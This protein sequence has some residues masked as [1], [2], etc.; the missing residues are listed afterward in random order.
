MATFSPSENGANAQNVRT[1]IIILR[2]SNGFQPVIQPHGKAISIGSGSSIEK[3]LAFLNDMNKPENRI[4]IDNSDRFSNRGA[5]TM[6]LLSSVML[7]DNVQQGISHHMHCTIVNE[8]GVQ[9]FP[10]D[11]EQSIGEAGYQITMPKVAESYSAFKTF[12]QSNIFNPSSAI[13]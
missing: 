2:H 6:A 12:E 7:K 5:M 10:L 8:N 9:S 4:A 3:Y 13:A 1:D 11:Y